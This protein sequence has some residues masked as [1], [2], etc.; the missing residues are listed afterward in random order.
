M[1]SG[2]ARRALTSAF[3]LL[4]FAAATVA[5][6]QVNFT[7]STTIDFFGFEG[8][9]FSPTPAFNQL[10]SDNWAATG[11]ST[12]SF[13]FGDTTTDTDSMR[14]LSTGGVTSGGIYAFDVDGLGNTSLGVQ[15][16]GSDFTPGSFILRLQNNTGATITSLDIAFVAY[17]NNNATRGNAFGFSYS[18]LTSDP[19][20]FI[21]VPA[22]SIAASAD[23][24]DANGFVANPLS[25]TIGGLSIADGALFYLQWSG[26]DV[27]GGGSR[28]EF[29]V[30]DIMVNLGGG[31]PTGSCS[32]IPVA[33]TCQ[34][35]TAAEC[36]MLGGMFTEGGACPSGACNLMDNSCVIDTEEGCFDQGGTYVGDG[37]PCTGAC[38]DL[39]LNQC[40]P[41]VTEPSCGEDGGVY[42]GDNSDCSGGCPM[43]VMGVVLNEIRRDQPGSDGDYIE[44][45]GAPGTDLTGLQVVVVGDPGSGNVERVIDLAGQNMGGDG[46]FLIADPATI[47]VGFDAIDLPIAGFSNENS[48]NL[49]FFLVFGFAGFE[50]DDLD[51]DDDCLI[52][53]PEPWIDELDRV[54]L[55]ESANDNLPTDGECH[56]ATM[57]G[58]GG[59]GMGCPACAGD[60]DS[61]GTRDLGDVMGF[62]DALLNTGD[63]CADIN[64]DTAAD[65]L[66]ID[67]F[68]QLVLGETACPGGMA[69]VDVPSQI[70]GPDGT[71][72]TAHAFRFPNETGGWQL[73]DFD[74]ADSFDTAGSVNMVPDGAC[75]LP[76]SCIET[77]IVDCAAQ[78]GVFR[79][80]NSLCSTA[81]ICDPVDISTVQ[82]GDAGDGFIVGPV[83]VV[84]LV[85]FDGATQDDRSFTVQDQSGANIGPGGTARGLTIIFD[86]VANPAIATAVDMLS[87]GDCVNVTGTLESVGGAN[88]MRIDA[89][90][91]IESTTGC[92]SIPV[93][94]VTA[95]NFDDTDI[96]NEV[97]E[98]VRVR[99]DCVLVSDNAGADDGLFEAFTSYPATDGFDAFSVRVNTVPNGMPTILG[100]MIPVDAVELE[101]V[102]STEFGTRLRLHEADDIFTTNCNFGIG[103][104]CL[105]DQSCIEVSQQICDELSGDFSFGST[106]AETVCV[107]DVGAC[108][109]EGVCSESVALSACSM[110][111]GLFLG[112]MSTCPVECPNQDSVQISEIRQSQTGADVNEFIEISGAP[113]TP[114]TGLTYIVIGDEDATDDSGII[115]LVIDLNSEIIPADGFWVAAETATL[116]NGVT[117]VG[118]VDLVI[119]LNLEDQDNV[120]HLLVR[121]FSGALGDDLDTVRAD[122]MMP[123]DEGGNEDCILD[124]EP[125]GAELDRIALIDIEN[126]TNPP[127]PGGTSFLRC[128]YGPP[129]I[130]PDGTFLPARVFRCDGDPGGPWFI[131]ANAF[132][133]FTGDTPGG[134]NPCGNPIGACCDTSSGDCTEITES[135]CTAMF[136]GRTWQGAD[137]TCAADCMTG[138]SGQG[139]VECT[140][141]VDCTI[142]DMNGFCYYASDPGSP[143]TQAGCGASAPSFFEV[144]CPSTCDALGSTATFVIPAGSI[145]PGNPATDCVVEATLLDAGGNGASACDPTGQLGAFPVYELAP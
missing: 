133:D 101:G 130:G 33:P 140:P 22:L 90:S 45:A 68:I 120:T 92:S 87:E 13:D 61:S 122:M 8:A 74:P 51:M 4:T 57:A 40:A 121:D 58:M 84:E 81:G 93:V 25:A 86:E 77:N 55:I 20:D 109:V 132:F 143:I 1:I 96:T 37:T 56:Y 3:C 137:T 117:A 41:N 141:G 88:A 9:G 60:F 48:D 11:F 6:A 63:V 73:G 79:G 15:P 66:D 136:P 19:A 145:S 5:H 23:A 129:T 21:A 134:P 36:T 64:A 14:G 62:V 70:V 112:D 97:L 131:G 31:D 99:I 78:S 138:P 69:A 76:M 116:P 30:D 17:V 110:M 47:S 38:C 106:C 46:I 16:T 50:G 67:P 107:E 32:S 94:N 115:E 49:T 119:D 54:A 59:G 83:T 104:C 127:G 103:S 80:A 39:A 27:S 85:D 114:L 100:T 65:G 34:T 72:A 128:H 113:G 139:L 24:P 42:L 98:S 10:D 75:C 111:G 91:D 29:A 95:S 44:L 2:I 53:T 105:A 125:W 144:A 135:D 108:C 82:G 52:D 102:Y 123:G 28:D 126:E 124:L 71:F 18:T 89:A 43:G 12:G 142:G 118:G 26:D 35:T 7:G